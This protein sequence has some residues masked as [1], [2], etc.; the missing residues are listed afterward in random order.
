MD[1]RIE[2]QSD[3]D[4]LFVDSKPLD[5]TDTRHVLNHYSKLATVTTAID[6]IRYTELVD[7]F[8]NAIP[9]DFHQQFVNIRVVSLDRKQEDQT[10]LDQRSFIEFLE[11]CK[12]LNVLELKHINL[13]A[14]FYSR[15]SLSCPYLSILHIELDEPVETP[16]MCFIL[17]YKYL[18]EFSINRPMEY[19]VIHRCLTDLKSF[20]LLKC[21]IN[22]K[23]I[24]IDQKRN[25]RYSLKISNKNLNSSQTGEFLEALENLFALVGPS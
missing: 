23:P 9:S 20:E 15:L 19:R 1:F 22:G 13:G 10:E 5:M 17:N 24:E 11:K 4:D 14:S 18:V 12:V 3:L 6:T 25:R 16:D 8:G 21:E 7:H 2:N